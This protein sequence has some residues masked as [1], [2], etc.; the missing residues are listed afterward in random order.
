MVRAEIKDAVVVVE[1]V[2]RAVT[3]VIVEIDDE[4]AADVVNLLQVTR[5]DGDVVEDAEPHAAIACRVMAGR[6]HRAERVLHTA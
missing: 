3:V 1:D 5:G 6:A 2:L 4:N